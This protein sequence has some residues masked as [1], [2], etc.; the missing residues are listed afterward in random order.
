MLYTFISLND[1]TLNI[2]HWFI[3]WKHA[4]ETNVCLFL[5]IQQFLCPLLNNALMIRGITLQLL[6]YGVHYVHF[7]VQS[8][9]NNCFEVNVNESTN[10]STCDL[11]LKYLPDSFFIY[12]TCFPLFNNLICFLMSLNVGLV[13]GC[14]VRQLFIN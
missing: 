13:A 14:S 3:R 7:A 6:N 5:L 4:V 12:D 9:K 1:H 10:E 11:I 2:S 8:C